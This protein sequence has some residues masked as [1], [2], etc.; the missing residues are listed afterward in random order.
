MTALAAVAVALAPGCAA[1]DGPPR[2][3][4][5]LVVVDTLRADRLTD[6]GHDRDTLGPVAALAAQATRFTAAYAP[7]SWTRPSVATIFSGMMPARHRAKIGGTN[8]L[9]RAIPTLAETLGA[10]GW[11][12]AGFSA[13]V[14]VSRKV[15]FDQGFDRFLDYE[16]GVQ[17]YPDIAAMMRVASDWLKTA[18]RPF[19]LFLQPMNVHG[20]YRVP[21]EHQTVLL[22]R[23]PSSDFRY[24]EPPRTSIMAGAVEL[25][26]SIGETYLTSLRDQYDTAIRY[27]MEQLDALFSDLRRE[28]LWD[29]TLIVLTSDHGEELYDH[30]G[31]SHAYSLFEEVVRVPLYVKLPGQ[32]E[33][34]VRDDPVSLADIY[35]TV[36]EVL[37]LPP[38]RHGDGRSLL[39]RGESERELVFEVNNPERF[40]GRALLSGNYKLIETEVDYQGRSDA[41]ALYDLSRDPDE[42][43]DLVNDEPELAARLR[44][45]MEEIFAGYEERSLPL[46]AEGDAVLDQDTLRALGYVN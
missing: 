5:L 19:F 33:P 4:V 7:S 18:P 13:N 45:R 2:P 29:E 44:A 12:T 21:V 32:L 9:N 37:G 39:R 46:P 15:D 22:G 11:S 17:A 16:G 20:P 14:V 23:R 40:R 24:Q 1:T 36:L 8:R 38:V 3:S 25:R 10:A 43:R 26:S 28:G 27:S 34:A 42:S 41:V 30:Q 6:Y 35:P 31:F